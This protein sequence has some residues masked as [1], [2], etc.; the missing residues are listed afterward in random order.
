MSDYNWVCEANEPQPPL[1]Q[2]ILGL[3]NLP[4][5]PSNL[6]ILSPHISTQTPF[7]PTPWISLPHTVKSPAPAQNPL[8]NCSNSL[9][10]MRMLGMEPGPLKTQTPPL[11]PRNSLKRPTSTVSMGRVPSPPQNPSTW[12]SP[13]DLPPS[14]MM[15][16]KSV[17]L[18]Q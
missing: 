6:I 12:P 13:W 18:L 3:L 2:M 4:P 10:S 9:L 15:L 17:Q 8:S 16:S 5:L 11:Q 1:P 7:N 14:L